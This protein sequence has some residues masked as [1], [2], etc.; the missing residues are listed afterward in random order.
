MVCGLVVGGEVWGGDVVDGGGPT[1]WARAC[2]R[3]PAAKAAVVNTTIPA[4]RQR[5]FTLLLFSPPRLLSC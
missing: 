1:I 4:A 3:A 2:Q 5:E